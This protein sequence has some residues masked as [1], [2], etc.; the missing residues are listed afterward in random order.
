VPADV[1]I[2][3]VPTPLK[4]VSTQMLFH[5]LELF[6][7]IADKCGREGKPVQKVAVLGASYK[8]SVFEVIRLG[9]GTRGVVASAI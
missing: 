7:F 3:A 5:V 8:A 6:E 4:R 9:V 1:F 2:I